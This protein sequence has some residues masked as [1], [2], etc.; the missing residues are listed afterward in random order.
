M[1]MELDKEQNYHYPFKGQQTYIIINVCVFVNTIQ[2]E[3][4]GY[5]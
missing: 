2:M 1:E 3:M 5:L 4:D